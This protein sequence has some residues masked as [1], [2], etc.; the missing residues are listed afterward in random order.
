MGCGVGVGCCGVL[1]CVWVGGVILGFAFGWLVG[2]ALA[3][4]S[5]VCWFVGCVR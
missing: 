3:L 1:G 4:L 2:V 5:A